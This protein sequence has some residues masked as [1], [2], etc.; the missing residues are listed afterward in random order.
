M[1]KDK[2][3][4]RQYSLRIRVAPLDFLKSS[5]PGTQ[6]ITALCRVSPFLAKALHISPVSAV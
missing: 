5:Y 3:L 6:N 4:E 1:K 2:T